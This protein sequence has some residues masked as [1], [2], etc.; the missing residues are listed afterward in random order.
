M[1]TLEDKVRD[2]VNESITNGELF[3]AL[4]ISNKVKSVDPLIKHREVRDIVRGLFNTDI[5]NQGYGRTPINVTLDDGSKTEALLYH[6]L[7]DS[8]DLDTK[9]DAQ[10]RAQIAA[11]PVAVAT[12]NLNVTPVVT[13]P[14]VVAPPVPPTPKQVWDNLFTPTRLFPKF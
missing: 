10:R 12:A 14:V 7:S 11:N 9:Y 4:D 6:A 13:P 2:I 5:Q 8:W 1:S 3:T